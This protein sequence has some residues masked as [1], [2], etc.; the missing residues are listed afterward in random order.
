MITFPFFCVKG[1]NSPFFILLNFQM[2]IFSHYFITINFIN[3]S[4]KLYLF[5]LYLFNNDLCFKKYF[6]LFYL[7]CVIKKAH[8]ELSLKHIYPLLL[9]VL[10]RLHRRI[11]KHSLCLGEI[12]HLRFPASLVIRSTFRKYSQEV[13][14]LIRKS[15]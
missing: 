9:R 11:R 12:R 5:F 13:C 3:S 6:V 4:H 7:K 8:L 1:L 15:C 10:Y 2:C 14:R